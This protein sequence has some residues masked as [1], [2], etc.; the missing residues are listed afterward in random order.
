MIL[1]TIIILGIFGLSIQQI[2]SNNIFYHNIFCI[3]KN[4]YETLTKVSYNLVYNLSYNIVYI[5]SF[6][7]IHLRNLK[8]KIVFYIKDIQK[9]FN[10]NMNN[11][12][13]QI[14]V[15]IIN[16]K[17]DITNS[18]VIKDVIE[19]TSIFD[20]GL[21]LNI[22]NNNEVINS[23]QVNKI[24]FEKIPLSID[25]KLSNILFYT[26]D[27][28][29]NNKL[30]IITLKHEKYNYYIVNNCLNRNFFRYY[31]KNILHVP[32]TDTDTFD[33]SVSIIDNNVNVI[34]LLPEQ[35]LIFNEN[36]YTIVTENNDK[37]QYLLDFDYICDNKK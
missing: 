12:S 7:Q 27:L 23:N 2:K 3:K 21:V 5:F 36:D 31:L 28:T 22:Q 4:I 6:S 9:Y 8:N 13:K 19:I 35:C 30:Y 10:M 33:Y 16:K 18:L 20:C 32:I 37:D 25:Y 15:D 34:T 11:I 17:G 24:Y 29:Y 26:I 1:T 14:S